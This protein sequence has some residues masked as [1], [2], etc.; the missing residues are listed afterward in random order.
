MRVLMGVSLLVLLA[1]AAVGDDK[2][3]PEKKGS[4][5]FTLAELAGTWKNDTVLVNGRLFQ[6]VVITIQPDG[7]AKSTYKEK[8][9]TEF[10]LSATELRIKQA[11]VTVGKKETTVTTIDNYLGV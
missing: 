8:K 1:A 6:N 10:T 4:S 2:Q 11:K 5:D 3:P 9:G 7:K